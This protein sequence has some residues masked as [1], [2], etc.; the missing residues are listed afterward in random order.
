[1]PDPRDDSQLA[2]LGRS[3]SE[4]IDAINHEVG[5]EMQEC[6][7]SHFGSDVDG[8]RI[9]F[10]DA[11]YVAAVRV[12]PN[13]R[14]AIR[15]SRDDGWAAPGDLTLTELGKQAIDDLHEIAEYYTVL[16]EDDVRD[17]VWTW[18]EDS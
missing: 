7:R 11:W 9:E 15:G 4:L 3:L 1:M 13:A 17:C 14:W 6:C 12:N 2:R 10:S 18:G 5:V 8:V 16:L